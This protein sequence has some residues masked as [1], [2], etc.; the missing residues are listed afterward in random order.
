MDDG[1]GAFTMELQAGQI[2]HNATMYHGSYP[3][4]ACGVVMSPVE[5]MY[6]YGVCPTCH[7]TRSSKR[8]ARKMAG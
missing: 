6:S 8:V 1:D 2:A 5:V 7:E 4:P 3:C